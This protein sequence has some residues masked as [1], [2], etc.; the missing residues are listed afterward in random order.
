MKL[1]Y[2]KNYKAPAYKIL[3]TQLEF[4]LDEEKTIVKSHLVFEQLKKDKEFIINKNLMLA[5]K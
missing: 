1:T 3:T 2:R 5:K 4:N